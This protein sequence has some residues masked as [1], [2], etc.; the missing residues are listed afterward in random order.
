MSYV[1]YDK[2]ALIRLIF[3]F[4]FFLYFLSKH[5]QFLSFLKMK[6]TACVYLKNIKKKLKKKIKR[7]NAILYF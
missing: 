4:N 6:E 2:I 5:K 1:L 7:I 3:F